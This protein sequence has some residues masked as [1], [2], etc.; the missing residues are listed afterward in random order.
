MND[1]PRNAGGK[2]SPG[3]PGAPFHK[4]ESRPGAPS[5]K[6]GAPA[7]KPKPKRGNKPFSTARPRA[8]G[9]GAHGMKK[10]GLESLDK[11]AH[12]KIAPVIDLTTGPAVPD[13][14]VRVTLARGKSK[15]FWIGHPWVFSGAIDKVEGN[16]GQFGSPCVVVDER[17]NPLGTGHYSPDAQIA[18]RLMWHRRTTDLPFEPPSFENI[19]S[20]RIGDALKLRASLGFPTDATN[21]YR[22]INAEGDLLPG[23][24][25]DRLGDVLSLQFGSRQM[26]DARESIVRLLSRELRPTRIVASVSETASRLEGIPIMHELEPEPAKGEH[27]SIDIRENGLVYR[28]D[29]TSMQKT[30]FYADQREN[31]ARFGALSAGKS[32][33]DAYCHYGGFGLAAARAGATSVTQV[34]TSNPALEGAR[35]AARLNGLDGKIEALNADAIVY[36]K[37]QQA[38]NRTWDRIVIDPP[39]FAQGRSHL[40]DALQKYARLNTLAMATLAPGGLLLTCSCSRHVGEEEFGRMLTE[41]GHRLRKSVRVL[42][43]WGQPADHPTVSVA[44]EGRYLKAWLVALG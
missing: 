28:I 14:M 11:P 2:P 26:L 33:L 25:V 34:D 37:E 32:M 7:G 40:E 9:G 23:L 21:V 38:A 12:S 31:R 1:K 19:L 16:V 20:E 6:P 44:P 35:E 36:L 17:G 29:L 43:R 8:E 27:P 22:V 13:G 41:S 4:P 30:G 39:K 3:K 18:V 15:P 5:G 42:E 10:A 24:V